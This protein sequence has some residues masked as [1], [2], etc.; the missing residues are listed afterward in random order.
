MDE[1]YRWQTNEVIVSINGLG[2]VVRSYC[3][4]CLARVMGPLKDLLPRPE[5]A[6]ETLPN[7]EKVAIPSG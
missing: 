1:L 3:N 2:T 5:P 7:G 6:I 4:E